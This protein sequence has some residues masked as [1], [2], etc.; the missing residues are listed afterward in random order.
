MSIAAFYLDFL[1]KKSPTPEEC[2]RL[3]DLLASQ[4][5]PDSIDDK[6]SG[7]NVHPVVW[8]NFPS[9]RMQFS[10]LEECQEHEAEHWDHLLSPQ[11]TP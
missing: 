1:F 3:L 2:S 11:Q 7:E 10:A 6:F 9:C 5:T 4:N 8:C